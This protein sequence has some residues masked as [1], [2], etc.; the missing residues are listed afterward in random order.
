MKLLEID[1]W[2]CCNSKDCPYR[3]GCANH[4][5]AGDYRT[6]DGFSPELVRLGSDIYCKSYDKPPM[7]VD[8]NQRCSYDIPENVYDLGNGFV[9]IEDVEDSLNYI[10]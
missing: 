6:D 7:V 1:D 4:S 3:R 8:E 10:I 2:K 9:N 5:S